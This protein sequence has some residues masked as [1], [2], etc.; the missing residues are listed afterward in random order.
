MVYYFLQLAPKSLICFWYEL[1]F[2]YA[3]FRRGASSS[4]NF[5]ITSMNR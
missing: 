4:H 5:S 3:F 2:A 1:K